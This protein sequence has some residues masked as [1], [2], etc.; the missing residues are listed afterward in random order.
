M[1]TAVMLMGNLSIVND[2]AMSNLRPYSLSALNR[3]GYSGAPHQAKP[4]G[5]QINAPQITSQA[6]PEIPQGM[7]SIT[8]ISAWNLE[9]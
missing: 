5:A 8:G 9:I 7:N 4:D 6:Y 1:C 3:T 2:S